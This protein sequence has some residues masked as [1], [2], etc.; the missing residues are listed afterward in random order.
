M[1]NKKNMKTH[2]KKDTNK[3]KTQKY[4]HTHGQKHTNI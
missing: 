2:M 1:N 3:N 4:I